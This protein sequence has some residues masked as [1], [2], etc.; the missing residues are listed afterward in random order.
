VLLI[1]D[2]PVIRMT[3]H[4][5]KPNSVHDIDYLSCVSLRLPTSKYEAIS[6]LGV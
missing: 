3:L 4:E 6:G 2:Q 5:P 1:T